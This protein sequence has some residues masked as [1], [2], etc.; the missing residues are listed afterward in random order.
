MIP[1]PFKSGEIYKLTNLGIDP[2]FFKFGVTQL[3]S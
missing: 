1:A 2:K 3:E